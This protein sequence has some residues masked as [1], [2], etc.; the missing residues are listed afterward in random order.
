MVYQAIINK[1]HELLKIE[2]SSYN[3]PVHFHKRL[4]I[5]KVISG[6]K[7]ITINNHENNF[8][9]NDVYVI[10]PY[11]AHSCKTNGKC[12]YSIF[13]LDFDEIKNK[14]ILSEGAN[15]LGI[16]FSKMICLINDTSFNTLENSIIK[17]I[18]NY[19]EEDYNCNINDIANKLG[20]NIY[21]AFIQRENRY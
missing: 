15:F 12:N 1:K 20:Y 2:N 6:E 21:F 14:E 7:Y 11:T 10:P 16:N 9:K 3:F 17:Y 18:I 13:S 8:S 19:I 4:C 5:G